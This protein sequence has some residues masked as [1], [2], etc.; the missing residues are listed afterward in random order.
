MLNVTSKNFCCKRKLATDWR[1]ESIVNV[2]ENKHL[3]PRKKAKL[4]N[5]YIVLKQWFSGFTSHNAFRK[6]VVVVVEVVVAL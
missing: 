6:V 4:I 1:Y 5:Y 2:R 3:I